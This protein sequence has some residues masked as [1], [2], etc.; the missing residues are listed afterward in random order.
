MST[1]IPEIDI[2]SVDFFCLSG[3]PV[4]RLPGFG[5]ITSFQMDLV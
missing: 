3:F 4:A 1:V 2:L 5:R